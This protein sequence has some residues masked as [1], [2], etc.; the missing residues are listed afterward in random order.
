MAKFIAISLSILAMAIGWWFTTYLMLTAWTGYA[1][2]RL[3]H[4]RARGG[5]W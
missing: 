3:V 5:E 1:A 4:Y 2:Y